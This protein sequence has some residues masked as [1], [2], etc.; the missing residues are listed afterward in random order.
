M[1]ESWTCPLP[2]DD[3]CPHATERDNLIEALE[4]LR[5][6]C[7]NNTFTAWQDK[8]WCEATA[9]WIEDLLNNSLRPSK[10]TEEK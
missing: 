10:I 1:P 9:S 7:R 8:M 4:G 5:D 2:L 3:Y 6:S